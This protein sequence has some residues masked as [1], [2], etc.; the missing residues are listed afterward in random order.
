M[1]RKSLKRYTLVLSGAQVRALHK[2]ADYGMAEAPAFWHTA[3]LQAAIRAL[4]ELKAVLRKVE[5][6]EKP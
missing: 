3:S 2:I 5:E 1:N 6:D 4:I